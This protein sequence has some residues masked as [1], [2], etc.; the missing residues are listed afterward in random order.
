MVDQVIY[1]S[2]LSH[3][4]LPPLPLV[5]ADAHRGERVDESVDRQVDLLVRVVLGRVKDLRAPEDDPNK[6]VDLPVD[7]FVEALAAM[8]VRP[9]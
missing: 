3:P 6:Q 4:P 5:R 2:A 8:G 7:G 1:P 9:N